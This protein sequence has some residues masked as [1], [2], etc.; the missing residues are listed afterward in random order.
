MLC[1]IFQL[2][3]V[4]S[5]EAGGAVV[6][7]FNGLLQCLTALPAA[8]PHVQGM[9]ENRR[10]TASTMTTWAGGPGGGDSSLWRKREGTYG[11]LVLQ[12]Y[13]QADLEKVGELQQ[14][15]YSSLITFLAQTSNYMACLKCSIAC[16]HLVLS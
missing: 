13:I 12:T 6:E 5:V 4:L 2:S 16:T 8:L 14:I 3:P 11:S 15:L 7:V 10:K 9:P 1:N